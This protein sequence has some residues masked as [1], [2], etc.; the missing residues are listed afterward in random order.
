MRQTLLP[1]AAILLAAFAAPQATDWRTRIAAAPSG[2]MVVGNPEAR[3]KLVEYLSYTCSHCAHFVRDSAAELKDKMVRTG[4]VSVEYRPMVRNALDLAAAIGAR[5]AGPQGF[6]RAQEAVF[7]NQA[8]LL[9]KAQGLP[10]ATGTP[11]Q[12]LQT[13]A[14]GSGLT[15][16]LAANGVPK[17]RFDQCLADPKALEPVVAMTRDAQGRIKG[18][19]S[20]EVNGELLADVHDWGN[21]APRLRAAGAE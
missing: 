4:D 16:V 17:A 3:V 9:E 18:T 21:L 6:V 20:F 15:A 19:P 5:C 1:A 13:L 7:D 8:A 11:A 2:A 10:E 14:Q 12:K